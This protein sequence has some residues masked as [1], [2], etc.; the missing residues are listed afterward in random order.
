MEKQESNSAKSLNG[1]ELNREIKQ[2]CQNLKDKGFINSFEEEPRYNYPG[3]N[4]SSYHGKSGQFSPDFEI[5]LN[6]G[7]II[8]IDNTT[9]IR[10][11]RLKQK[12]WDAY[13]VKEYYRNKGKEIKYYV[14]APNDNQLGSSPSKTKKEK[15]NLENNREKVRSDNDREYFSTID[16]IL[17]IEDLVTLI[18]KI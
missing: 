7:D 1:S 17:Q 11:D 3:Y 14:V 18:T 10:H 5:E 15:R 9:T 13:G 16:D 6:N 8:V 4:Y 12:L 2:I